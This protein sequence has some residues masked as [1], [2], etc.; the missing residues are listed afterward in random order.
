M[1]F[2]ILMGKDGK[3]VCPCCRDT[4]WHCEK[5][6]RKFHNSH[7]VTDDFEPPKYYGQS[8]ISDV[9]REEFGKLGVPVNPKIK[10]DKNRPYKEG[11][12]H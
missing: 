10:P 12:Y 6:W 8:M 9:L 11:E 7:G 5:C 3:P 1:P 4:L 2:G